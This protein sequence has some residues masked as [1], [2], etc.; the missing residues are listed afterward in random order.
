MGMI[1]FTPLVWIDDPEPPPPGNRPWWLC[2]R[3]APLEPCPVRI[4]PVEEF[5]DFKNYDADFKFPLASSR[6]PMKIERPAY[7]S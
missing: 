4:N 3:P 1:A 6:K 7:V 2:V 5:V